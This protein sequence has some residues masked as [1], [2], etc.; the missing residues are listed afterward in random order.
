MWEYFL[1]AVKPSVARGWSSA[2]SSGGASCGKSVK[3]EPWH[4]GVQ[5]ETK[6]RA[7]P[8]SPGTRGVNHARGG[9]SVPGHSPPELQTPCKGQPSAAAPCLAQPWG[10]FLPLYQPCCPPL[11]ACRDHTRLFMLWRPELHAVFKVRPEKRGWLQLREGCGSAE[12]CAARGGQ[13]LYQPTSLLIQNGLAS[14]LSLNSHRE[15]LERPNGQKVP[16][17]E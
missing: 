1:L 11:G 14:S 5:E 6:S 16:Y 2:A 13:V 17:T 12:C 15:M 3:G 7:Q 8:L 10:A 4:Q 9:P